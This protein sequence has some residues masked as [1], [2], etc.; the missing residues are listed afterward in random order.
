MVTN[1]SWAIETQPCHNFLR[2]FKA[3]TQSKVILGRS[4]PISFHWLNQQESAEILRRQKFRMSTSLNLDN[5]HFFWIIE[6]G[7]FQNSSKSHQHLQEHFDH[8]MSSSETNAS[9]S[10]TTT[11]PC[12][13][14][15]NIMVCITVPSRTQIGVLNPVIDPASNS[16][17]FPTVKDW[18]LTEFST[19]G[20]RGLQ[21]TLSN[22]NLNFYV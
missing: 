2:L 8:H 4:G 22:E 12:P 10:H 20:H 14:W 21:M 15:N 1:N 16:R 6:L 13:C 11:I 18:S 19:K 7:N 17:Q 9:C 3:Y 5:F